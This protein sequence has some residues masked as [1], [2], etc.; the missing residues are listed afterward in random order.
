MTKKYFGIGKNS[1]MNI[2]KNSFALF[3]GFKMLSIAY[4]TPKYGYI[5]RFY[6]YDNLDVMQ[7]ADL[8]EPLWFVGLV[9]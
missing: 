4:H 1:I 7:E 5:P 3:F 2:N 9:F 8:F 6:F